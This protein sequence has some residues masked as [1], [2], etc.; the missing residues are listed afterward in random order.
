MELLELAEVRCG[1]LAMST[2]PRPLLRGTGRGELRYCPPHT[3][4]PVVPVTLARTVALTH[5][6]DTTPRHSTPPTHSPGDPG[7]RRPPCVSPRSWRST[8]HFAAMLTVD[9]SHTG[10]QELHPLTHSIESPPPRSLLRAARLAT[11]VR[12][13]CC[14]TSTLPACPF[15]AGC[16]TFDVLLLRL[17]RGGW[18]LRCTV[19]ESGQQ[20]LP[21]LGVCGVH[22]A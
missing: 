19:G 21:I 11:L 13:H 1:H 5:L 10:P 18:P 7:P 2:R 17:A 16:R 15:W 4:S 22:F 12:L 20:P 8:S 14:H 9:S 6:H 3:R